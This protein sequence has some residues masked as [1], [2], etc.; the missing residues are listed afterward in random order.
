MALTEADYVTALKNFIKDH[1]IKNILLKYQVENTTEELT[2]YVQMAIGFLNSIPPP[3][4]AYDYGTFPIPSLI[5]HQAALECLIS[6]GICH[7]RNE[8]SYNNGGITVKIHDSERYLKYIQVLA[9]MTDLEISNFTKMKI[10]LNLNSAWG[11]VYSP[12]AR[13]HG[14]GRTLQPNSLLAG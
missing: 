12:Y 1:E 2:M 7:A 3:I 14:Q 10:S 13:L 4:Y 5:I 6:N 8:L 11:G 9:R